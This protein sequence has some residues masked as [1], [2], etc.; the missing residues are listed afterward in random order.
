M[1][2]IVSL[3]LFTVAALDHPF[4]GDVRIHPTAFEQVLERFHESRLSDLEG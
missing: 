2:L 4:M 1:A 3:T